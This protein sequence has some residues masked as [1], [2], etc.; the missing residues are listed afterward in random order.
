MAAYQVSLMLPGWG[1]STAETKTTAR[2]PWEIEDGLWERIAPLLPVVRR[3]YR[4]PGRKRLDDRKV[5]C[6]ILFV[7]Y[8]GIRWEFLP[9]ESDLCRVGGACTCPHLSGRR[10]TCRTN[11]T[12]WP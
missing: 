2:K 1:C 8:T 5:L 12:E 4:H 7:L 11:P 3:R 10:T 6:G 9:L